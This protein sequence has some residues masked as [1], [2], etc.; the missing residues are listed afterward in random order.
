VE[1]SGGSRRKGRPRLRWLENIE[2]NLW[3]INFKRWRE[4]AVDRE[5]Q[6]L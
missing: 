5:E 1:T 4:Y 3:E 6:A 2:K